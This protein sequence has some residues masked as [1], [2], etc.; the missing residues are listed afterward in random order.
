MCLCVSELAVLLISHC[1]WSSAIAVLYAFREQLALLPSLVSLLLLSLTLRASVALPVKVRNGE[2]RSS[3][4][5]VSV[6]IL[7]Q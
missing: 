2:R 1:P 6:G 3:Q 7:R 4:E 5:R